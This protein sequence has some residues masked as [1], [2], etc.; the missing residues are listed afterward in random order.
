MNETANTQ[1]QTSHFAL[2]V[3]DAE[4]G[5]R[6]A[7]ARV[8]AVVAL[9]SDRV[10]SKTNLETDSQ[11]R[12]DV[13]LAFPHPKIVVAG[14][15]VDGYEQKCVWACGLDPLPAGYVLKLSRG[16]R[17]GGV[18]QD[19]L[20]NPVAGAN[21]YVDFSGP[22]DVC[23]FP[24]ERPGFPND[25][26][27]AATTDLSGRWTFGCAPQT[28][29][30]FSLRVKHL[31][32]PEARFQNE[33]DGNNFLQ[34]D[35]FNL[36]DLRAGRAT[37]VLRSSLSVRGVVTDQRHLPVIGAQ[38]A[39]AGFCCGREPVIAQTG[40]DGSFVLGKLP[41]GQ[42]YITVTADG[43]APER[44][45]VEAGPNA[46]ALGFVLKP[47]ATLL[48][49]LVDESGGAVGNARVSVG[50][51]RGPYSLGWHALTDDDGRV[52]WTSAPHDQIELVA[53]K[54]GFF[55][56][57]RNFLLAD[58]REHTIT[59]RRQLTVRGRVIDAE[60]KQ[61]IAKFKAVAGVGLNWNRFDIVNGTNG[62]YELTFKE[63]DPTLRV[64]IDAEGYA[65]V[66]S[67]ELNPNAANQSCNIELKKVRLNDSV[68]GRVFLPDGKPAP[69]TQ[70]ALCTREQGATLGRA[71][72]L[73]RGGCLVVTADE[74]GHFSFPPE[75]FPRCVVAVQKQGFGT[76]RLDGA[77]GTVSIQL[78]P[79]GRIEGSLQLRHAENAGQR[80]TLDN[81][82]L[83]FC[84]RQHFQLDFREYSTNTG[85][86]GDFVFEQVPPGEF[87]LYWVPGMG[88]PRSHQTAVHV[89]PGAT[90]RVRIGGTGRMVKGRL[91]HPDASQAIDWSEQAAFGNIAVKLPRLPIPEGLTVEELQ[92]WETDF[93][94]SEEGRARAKAARNFPL[95]LQ[96]DG[97]FAIE[98]VPPGSYELCVE[99]F[100]SPY[101]STGRLPATAHLGSIRKDV[102]VPQAAGNPSTETLDIGLVTAA[103][104]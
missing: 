31:D 10:D 99:I 51:W 83:A 100:K 68:R 59:L 54:E 20:G 37:L 52:E 18:V 63:Y 36:E 21:L 97:S 96:A 39:F 90:L 8:L 25:D 22:S 70:I 50:S 13:P 58:S 3:I 76:V 32:Y 88:I 74:K 48:L 6:L 12:C 62:Q 16:S 98:D 14:V 45:P 56:S 77:G 102:I 44:M 24:V 55:N 92:K 35:A 1:G 94:E 95:M 79:W 38:V 86:Q 64:R 71:K 87:K 60:T 49:R 61:P 9:D 27:P 53:K 101:D 80:I 5:K 15:L 17:I 30:E 85:A 19:E 84:I 26:L 82:P 89:E 93:W 46:Q 67:Q 40:G 78:E 2:Q 4:T 11:G 81:A 72:F 33:A 73:D 41:G 69:G 66:I 23:Q 103:T 34:P 65:P 28:N 47:A 7:G 43:F 91:A 104:R 57:R 29:D 75:P 42:N